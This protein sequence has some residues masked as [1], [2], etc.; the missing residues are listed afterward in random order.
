MFTSKGWTIL[1]FL[2]SSLFIQTLYGQ[3]TFNTSLLLDDLNTHAM[4]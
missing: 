3:Q 4:T 2:I 1:K